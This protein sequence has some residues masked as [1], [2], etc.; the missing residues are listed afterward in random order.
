MLGSAAVEILGIDGK[1]SEIGTEL[2]AL[3]RESRGAR[4][5]HDRLMMGVDASGV[6][7]P[8]QPDRADQTIRSGQL[9]ARF[10]ASAPPSLE[11]WADTAGN[12]VRSAIRRP[13]AYHDDRGTGFLEEGAS[14]VRSTLAAKAGSLIRRGR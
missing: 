7:D 14:S 4:F 10:L 2:V 5:V 8:R 1:R 11:G 9:L 13:G 12:V 3:R 6:I